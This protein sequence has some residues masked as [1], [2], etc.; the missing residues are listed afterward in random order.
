MPSFKKASGIAVKDTIATAL[1]A[2]GV[3]MIQNGEIVAGGILVV[4]GWI[5]YV[6]DRYAIGSG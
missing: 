4:A 3:N 5:L 2:L 1:I 6:I